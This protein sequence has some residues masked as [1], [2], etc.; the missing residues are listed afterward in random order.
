MRQ[1]FQKHRAQHR[2]NGITD[3]HWNPGRAQIKRKNCR[4]RNAQQA[5]GKAGDDNPGQNGKIRNGH[6]ALERNE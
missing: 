1:N 6:A 2:T 4:Q 5:T 3:Q